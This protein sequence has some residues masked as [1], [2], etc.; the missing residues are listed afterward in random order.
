MASQRHNYNIPDLDTCYY[1]T[2][3]Q[4]GQNA[5]NQYHLMLGFG[6]VAH[7]WCMTSV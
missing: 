2:L 3:C 1:E 7:S 6:H 4:H 5:T